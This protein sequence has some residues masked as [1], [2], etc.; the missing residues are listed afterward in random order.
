MPNALG[1]PTLVDIAILN[2]CD[3][4]RGLVEEVV[5]VSPELDFGFADTIKGLNF[6]TQ[7][8]TAYGKVPFRNAN[9]GTPRFASNYE[10]RLCECFIMNP[11]WQPDRA[12][13]D[14]YEHGAQA[15]IAMEGL[16]M[17][18][19][20]MLNLSSQCYYGCANDPKGFPGFLSCVDESTGDRCPG[21]RRNRDHQRL[22][23]AL[24]NSGCRLAVGL[25]RPTGPLRRQGGRRL[26][27]PGKSL[28]GL[29]PGHH[30]PPR[31]G[32][33]LEVVA[34]PDQEH[35]GRPQ[36]HEPRADR[37]AHGQAPQRFSPIPASRT[38]SL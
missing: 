7:V 13:A 18:E 20:A 9:E 23:G 37:Q 3:A 4:T 25:E 34:G 21:H 33:A 10:S 1:Q 12:V 6:R 38:C 28:P 31:A 14:A 2:G 35:R 36:R 26:R 30:G 19:A 16:G 5:R 17:V 27:R 32:R 11:I 29:L 24:G 8:R 22:G 15:L